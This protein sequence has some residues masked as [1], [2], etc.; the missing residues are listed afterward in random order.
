MNSLPIF[1]LLRMLH[2]L[3]R[4][5]VEKLLTYSLLIAMFKGAVHPANARV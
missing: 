4:L 5:F 2:T 1:R 3:E